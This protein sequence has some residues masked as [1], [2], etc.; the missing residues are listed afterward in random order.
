M[1]MKPRIRAS[2][3]G[4]A[5]TKPLMEWTEDKN[6]EPEKALDNIRN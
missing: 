4:K 1:I 6:D 5:L 2:E 3:L